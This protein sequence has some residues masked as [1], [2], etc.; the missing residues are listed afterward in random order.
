MNSIGERETLNVVNVN[1]HNGSGGVRDRGG[2]CSVKGGVVEKTLLK[3]FQ[4]VF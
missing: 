4:T 3:F 1:G 2:G